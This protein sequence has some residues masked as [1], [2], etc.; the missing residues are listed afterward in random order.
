MA[1]RA[2]RELAEVTQVDPEAIVKRL[3]PT[4]RDVRICRTWRVSAA[5]GCRGGRCGSNQGV[6]V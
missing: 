6:P 2:I 3:L 4:V 5:G 1:N